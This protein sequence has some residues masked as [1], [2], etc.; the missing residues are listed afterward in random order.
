MRITIVAI[1]LLL[2]GPAYAEEFK[3]PRIVVTGERRPEVTEKSVTEIFLAAKPRCVQR[4]L[5]TARLESESDRQFKLR[6]DS[7]FVF[8][9]AEELAGYG[10]SVTKDTPS[11]TFQDS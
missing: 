8:C 2:A 4:A 6:Q 3:P 7:A 5:E 9:M 1:A 11:D 10:L